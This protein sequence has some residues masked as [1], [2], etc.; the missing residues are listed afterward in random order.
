[1][2]MGNCQ[3]IEPVRMELKQKIDSYCMA[4]KER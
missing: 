3:G 4:K 2:E 1:M